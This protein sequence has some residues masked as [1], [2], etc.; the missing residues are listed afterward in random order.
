MNDDV[1][2]TV[3]ILQ[4]GVNEDDL[5]LPEHHSMSSTQIVDNS[6]QGVRI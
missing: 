1:Q 2:Q 3:E 6:V 5:A 4:E